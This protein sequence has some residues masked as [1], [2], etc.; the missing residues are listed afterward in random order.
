[1]AAHTVGPSGSSGR[2]MG[3]RARL[4]E[5]PD[6]AEG[7]RSRKFVSI[8]NAQVTEVIG[9]MADV[10]NEAATLPIVEKRGY[11]GVEA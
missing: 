2:N 5:L 8:G 7:R 1:V 9:H 3:A 10:S 6:C 4:Q 11:R